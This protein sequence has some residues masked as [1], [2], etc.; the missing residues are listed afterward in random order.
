MR[1][2]CEPRRGQTITWIFGCLCRFDTREIVLLSLTALRTTYGENTQK[3]PLEESLTKPERWSNTMN[4]SKVK[5]WRSES[6]T[7][8]MRHARK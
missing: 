1:R 8:K 3:R 5:Y 7:S 2:Q 6:Q 4:Y